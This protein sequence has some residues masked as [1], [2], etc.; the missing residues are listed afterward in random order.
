MSILAISGN[1]IVHILRWFFKVVQR[2]IRTAIFFTC[3]KYFASTIFAQGTPLLYG[4]C[5]FKQVTF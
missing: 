3:Q 4:A 1:G 5:S 2:A